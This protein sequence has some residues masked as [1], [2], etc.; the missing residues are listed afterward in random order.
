[1]TDQE[2]FIAQK[3]STP[4]YCIFCEMYT[5]FVLP[6][7]ILGFSMSY[8]EPIEF[9]VAS[10][11]TSHEKNF[12]SHSIYKDYESASIDAKKAQK[13]RGFVIIPQKEYDEYMELKKKYGSE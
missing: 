5:Y 10:I 2:V 1:M 8:G 12:C 4:V 13:E 3:T 7:A 9:H 11:E 6:C